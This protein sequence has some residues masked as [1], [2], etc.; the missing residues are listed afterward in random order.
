MRRVTYVEIDAYAKGCGL[1]V[2]NVTE[3]HTHGWLVVRKFVP[4]VSE[5]VGMQL[6][7]GGGMTLVLSTQCSYLGY[8]GDWWWSQG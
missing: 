1:H 8:N 7:G 3:C 4:T 2:D 6:G 5:G